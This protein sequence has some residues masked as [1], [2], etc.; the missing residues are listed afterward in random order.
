M[1][2]LGTPKINFQYES[3]E[4]RNR[5]TDFVKKY[6]P[7]EEEKKDDEDE[8]KESEDQNHNAFQVISKIL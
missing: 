3:A 6:L 2:C 8:D 5:L 4:T 1:L 7:T